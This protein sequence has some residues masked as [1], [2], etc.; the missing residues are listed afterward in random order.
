MFRAG[1]ALRRR[2]GSLRRTLPATSWDAQPLLSFLSDSSLAD[3]DKYAVHRAEQGVPFLFDATDRGK[4]RKHFQRWDAQA[5]GPVAIADALCEGIFRFFEHQAI[6]LGC[7][8]NWHLHP[9]TGDEYP[10]DRHWSE[11]DDFAGGDIKYVWEP[12]RFAWVY[13]LV[14]AYWRTQDDRYVRLFWQLVL[15]WR[16]SNPPQHGVNWK[17]G[18]EVALRVMA[19]C[20]GLYGFADSPESTPSRIAKLVQ[21]LAVSGQ[22]IEANLGYALSQQNNHGIIEATGLWTLGLMFPEFA[23]SERW[24]RLG[25]ESLEDQCRKLI[26]ADGAFSQHSVN[27]Q[28][29]MLHACLWA[30]RLGELHG[31]PLSDELCDRVGRA[32]EFM[33]NLQ[34]EATGRLPRHGA[35]DG[36]LV[37]PLTNC[38]SQ[39]YRPVVQASA[40]VRNRKRMIEAGPWD[41]ELLW[42]GGADAVASLVEPD[43]RCDWQGHSSGYSVLRTQH[44]HCVTR[45]GSFRHRPAHAD[46][47]HADIWWRGQNVALDAGTY[48]YNAPPPWHTPLARTGSHNTVTVDGRDQMDRVGRFLWLPWLSGQQSPIV[49]SERGHLAY[50]E[51]SHDGYKRLASPVEYRRGILRI[52]SEH[53]LI[54][55]SLSSDAAHVYRLH[56]LLMDA[57]Y[58]LDE[59]RHHLQLKTP[60]GPYDACIAADATTELSCVRGDRECARGWYAPHYGERQPTVS[61]ACLSEETSVTFWTLLGPNVTG[62]KI[63][64]GQVMAT[65]PDWSCRIRHSVGRTSKSVQSIATGH[66]TRSEDQHTDGFGNPSSDFLID[67]VSLTGTLTDQWTGAT[68]RPSTD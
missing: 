46:M 31:Q 36:A 37:L 16:E 34:D 64:V 7:P 5:T 43:E 65:T 22:R 28:R 57:P 68:G 42:L 1:Y 26:D 21:L 52:G 58:E 24:T 38:E 6:N 61:L 44:G 18:Q 23:A 15:D 63:G 47:L 55:D 32:G 35:N 50:W 30:V 3:A 49:S 62:L 39:D 29:V 2:S 27:Y 9:V 17:C 59:P 33:W 56:W 66:T 54:V 41:E 51:G 11:I 13:P 4:W 53:W 45:A 8:P 10:V 20:F 48:S 67:S 60:Q 19:C 12:S 40:W 14:R 25:R